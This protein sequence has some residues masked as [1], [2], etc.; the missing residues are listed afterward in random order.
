MCEHRWYKRKDVEII[1]SDC[2]TF[3]LNQLSLILLWLRESTG[4]FTAWCLS[5]CV[6][7]THVWG[8]CTILSNICLD[9]CMSTLIV[10]E[11]MEG[12]WGVF[13]FFFCPRLWNPI[14]WTLSLCLR[15]S[16]I[17][18]NSVNSMGY[19]GVW[20]CSHEVFDIWQHFNLT[21]CAGRRESNSLTLC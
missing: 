1:D 3:K 14:L 18:L 11:V 21:G 12:V 6:W 5:V 13:F 10:W 20:L 8:V 2:L 16:K 4:I 9:V 19:S 17:K 15:S 7:H